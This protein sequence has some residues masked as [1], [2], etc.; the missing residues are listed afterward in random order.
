VSGGISNNTASNLTS[1]S[2]ANSKYIIV[3]VA[4]YNVGTEIPWQDI[5]DSLKIEEGTKPSS[6]TPYNC[7][8]IDITVCN[9]NLFNS[10]MIPNG[11]IITVNDDQSITLKN[12]TNAS[13]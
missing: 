7:G 2:L 5:L 6:Y 10:K 13:G 8:N 1:T 4:N 11:S 9:K 3:Y 12:N